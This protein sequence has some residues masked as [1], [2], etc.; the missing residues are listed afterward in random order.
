[1]YGRTHPTN[2]SREISWTAFSMLGTITVSGRWNSKMI[3]QKLLL[4]IWKPWRSKEQEEMLL[5]SISEITEKLDKNRCYCWI[6]GK[7]WRNLISTGTVLWSTWQIV[8][9]LGRNKYCP[10]AMGLENNSALSKVMRATD[11][12][13]CALTIWMR[14]MCSHIFGSS[15]F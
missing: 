15:R 1:M 6:P 10:S 13:Q 14:A 5:L 7:P 4:S 9:K 11:Y 8:G 12:K 3:E 2:C